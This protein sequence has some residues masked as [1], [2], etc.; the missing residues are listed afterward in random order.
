MGWIKWKTDVAD[1]I[2]NK[3]QFIIY[4]KNMEANY[5]MK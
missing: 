5:F 1:K 4:N 3:V 2:T